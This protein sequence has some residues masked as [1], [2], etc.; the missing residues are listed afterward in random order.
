MSRRESWRLPHPVA[1]A[2]RAAAHP[3]KSRRAA[4]N[5]DLP[6]FVRDLL[7][8]APPAGQGVNLWL[9][10]TACVLHPFRERHEIRDLLRAGTA[11]CGRDVSETEITRAVERSAAHAWQPGSGNRVRPAHHA[12]TLQAR[13]AWPS[14]NEECR[15]Q[16]VDT[17]GD[18]LVDLWEHSPV[19][20][21][22]CE[23]RSEEIIDAFFQGNPLLCAAASNSSFATRSREEWRGQLAALSLIVPSPMTA[24]TG[25]TQDGR[26]SA[27]TLANTGPRRFLIIEFDS[28]PPD[29]HAALHL[30]LAQGAPLALVVHSG[31]KSLHGWYY[32]AGKADEQMRDFMRY[33]VALG[34][35]RATWT[36]SQ[37]VRL[38][39]GLRQNG[40]R[41]CVYYFNPEV[42][43]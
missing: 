27:H 22:D 1:T 21:E 30:H 10:R 8:S 11:G 3:P 14:L 29:E 33:A 24:P 31:G 23:P 41:Q 19:R 38:P 17:T 34:A 16:L 26:E 15:R 4:R 37:F 12:A 2:A 35:D 40:A 6:R 36:R 18:G 5:G 13:Y 20:W 28:G 9:Y 7:A 39:D 42:I 32:C 25:R 43:R